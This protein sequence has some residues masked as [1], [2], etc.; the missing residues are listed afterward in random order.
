MPH[1][2]TSIIFTG[3]KV[4]QKTEEKDTGKTQTKIQHPS[5]GVTKWIILLQTVM[6][7]MAS[8]VKCKYMPFCA[9]EHVILIQSVIN[10]LLLLL[11]NLFRI[12]PKS[13]EILQK[14]L[15]W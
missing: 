15:D 6:K 14:L 8:V 9:C 1:S 5:D 11:L 12:N 2:V 10:Q 13:W 4:R 3:I 7:Q